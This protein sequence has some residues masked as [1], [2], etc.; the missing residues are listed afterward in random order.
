MEC[1]LCGS[2]F[3]GAGGRTELHLPFSRK[4][5]AE[6]VADVGF[7]VPSPSLL[8]RPCIAAVNELEWV[9]SRVVRARE[10]IKER[11]MLK[12][13]GGVCVG[14]GGVQGFWRVLG[15]CLEGMGITNGQ[16]S[17]M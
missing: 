4:T 1:T 7:H 8:C 10:K 5:V 12:V 17:P 13:R 3:R 14:R 16:A 15:C 2:E 11:A 6:M 9:M